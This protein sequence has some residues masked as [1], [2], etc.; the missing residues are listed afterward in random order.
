MSKRGRRPSARGAVAEPMTSPS[1]RRAK[2]GPVLLIVSAV[3][4]TFWPVVGFEFTNWDDDRSTSLNPLLNPP[5]LHSLATWWT[6]GNLGLYEPLTATARAAIALVARVPEDPRTQISLNP[7]VFHAAN[8]LLHVAVTLSVFGLLQQLGF[9]RWPACAAALLFAVHPVQVEPVAWVT[10]IKDLLYALLSLAAISRFLAFIEPDQRSA[11]RSAA[12]WG[13]T[14]LYVLA[15]LAKVTALVTPLIVLVLV[16]MQRGTIPRRVWRAVLF[17]LLLGVPIAVV[18]LVVQSS[19]TLPQVALWERPLIALDALAFY[20]GKIVW[21]ANLT[22]DYG[23]TPQEI[24]LRGWAWWTWIFPMALGAVFY[25]QRSRWRPVAAG[26]LVFAVGLLPVLGLLRFDFQ[27]YSTVADRYLY[28]PMFGVA[29]VVAWLLGRLPRRG[30]IW[31][32][33]PLALLAAC[34]WRQT[35]HWRDSKVLMSHAQQINPRSIAACNTLALLDLDQ[36]DLED[37]ETFA[38]RAIALRPDDWRGYSN[39]GA[40][41]ARE[42]QL[43]QATEAARQACALNPDGAVPLCDLGGLLARQGMVDEAL[44][45]VR[46]AIQIE[47][48]LAD[49]HLNLGSMLFHQRHFPESAREFK[50]AVKLRPYSITG[51]LNL[52]AACLAMGNVELAAEEYRAVL[53]IDP[54]SEAALSGL[55]RLGGDPVAPR[56]GS[57]E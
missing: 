30:A 48:D 34:S 22:I 45:L 14:T 52:A 12:F 57:G 50:L 23:R 13:A 11:A 46:R 39:L 37:A 32:A 25:I 35:W 2:R 7:Y 1:T 43:P 8:L 27:L 53:Q 56:S 31:S 54:Q 26:A 19:A 5:T 41:L 36:G 9:R 3:L 20:L 4:L 16:W 29:L 51:H 42:G 21:P 33:V 38:R 55:E 47:P 28:L 44:P 17:W 10:S 18:T 24:L 49:A 40:A 6:R 15:A